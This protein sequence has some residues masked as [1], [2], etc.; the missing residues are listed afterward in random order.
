MG[1][2]LFG[3]RM[4]RVPSAGFAISRSITLPGNGTLSILNTPSAVSSHHSNLTLIYILIVAIIIDAGNLP[5]SDLVIDR[6]VFR[7]F[8][9]SES[10]AIS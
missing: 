7:G 6:A 4:T 9:L 8:D 1:V 2:L 3:Y 5:A 10:C